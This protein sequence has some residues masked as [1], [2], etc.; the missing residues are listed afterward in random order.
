MYTL[1]RWWDR[2]GI[3]MLLVGATLGTAWM[4]RETQGAAILEVYQGMSTTTCLT[5]LKATLCFNWLCK[6]LALAALR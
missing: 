6:S 1:R 4:V 5:G 3:R 2:Y